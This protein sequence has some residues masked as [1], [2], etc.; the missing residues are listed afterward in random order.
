MHKTLYTE[1]S[2]TGIQSWSISHIRRIETNC[3]LKHL[4]CLKKRLIEQRCQTVWCI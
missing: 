3:V 1:Y 4:Y 2:T